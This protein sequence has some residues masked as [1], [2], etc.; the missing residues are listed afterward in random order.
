[1]T[2]LL[3]HHF[4]SG[5]ISFNRLCTLLSLARLWVGVYGVRKKNMWW[6]HM[7]GIIITPIKRE[8]NVTR[9][10]HVIKKYRIHSLLFQLYLYTNSFLNFIIGID[11]SFSET[12]WKL[13]AKASSFQSKTT[14][15]LHGHRRGE[16]CYGRRYRRKRA[17]HLRL[18]VDPRS[19]LHSLRS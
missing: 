7:L 15:F 14:I 11:L 9:T 12:F 16:T 8:H 4:I 10:I 5:K 18:G 19:F 13:L 3:R 1:M 17:E 6:R 2:D